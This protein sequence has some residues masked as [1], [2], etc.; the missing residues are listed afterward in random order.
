ME[1]KQTTKG[2]WVV[3]GDTHFSVWIEETGKL[4]HDNFLPPL[5]VSHLQAGQCVIDAGACYGDHTLAYSRALGKEGL[6]VAVEP[7][8]LSFECLKKNVE[9]FPFKNVFP[10]Q[11]CLG[12]IEGQSVSHNLSD[13]VG[14]SNCT[15]VEDR[16]PG[17]TYLVTVTLNYISE[18]IKRKVDFIKIDIE[19]FETQC[20]IGGSRLIQSDRPKMLIEI[21]S[22]ALAKQ[23]SNQEE[24]FEILTYHNYRWEIVQ[25]ECTLLSPQFDI[26]A[27]PNHKVHTP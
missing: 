3:D 15:L 10:I 16:I 7:G 8:K 27:L 18:L 14:A 23:N 4:D 9:L 21:N 25:P 24:I 2:W 17:E 13:N 5:V 6:C 26:L 12:E 20:L 11:A 19:G 22:S 1:L